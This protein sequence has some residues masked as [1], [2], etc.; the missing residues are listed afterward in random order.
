[1]SSTGHK[2]LE[3]AKMFLTA[4]KFDAAFYMQFLFKLSVAIDSTWFLMCRLSLVLTPFK[5]F[6]T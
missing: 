5:S 2:P 3:A 6:E 4:L 1:M